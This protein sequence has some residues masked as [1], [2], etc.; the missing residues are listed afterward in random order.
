MFVE[1][2]ADMTNTKKETG[3]HLVTYECLFFFFRLSTAGDGRDLNSTFGLCRS[4]HPKEQ[5][6]KQKNGFQIVLSQTS[7]YKTRTM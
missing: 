7:K 2:A 6:K 1:K 5:T 4:T 3:I